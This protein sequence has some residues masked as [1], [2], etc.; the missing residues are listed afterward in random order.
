MGQ[1]ACIGKRRNVYNIMVGKH[2]G[3]RPLEDLDIVWKI[4]LE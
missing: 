3:E 1:V 2:E 4:I